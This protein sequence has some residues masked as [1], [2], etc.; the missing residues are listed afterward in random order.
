MVA[1]ITSPIDTLLQG[2]TRA[3]APGRTCTAVPTLPCK[4]NSRCDLRETKLAPDT[5]WG[6]RSRDPIGY[7]DG[8]CLYGQYIRMQHLDSM[9]LFCN[10]HC[11][12][13]F[14]PQ[15]VA[16]MPYRN[17][18][19]LPAA[20]GQV[21]LGVTRVNVED[22]ECTCKKD[23]GGWYVD[24]VELNVVA[25]IVIDVRLAKIFGPPWSLETVYGHEQRHVLNFKDYWENEGLRE[26]CDFYHA[27]NRPGCKYYDD[28]ITCLFQGCSGDLLNKIWDLKSEFIDREDHEPDN[29]S[30]PLPRTPYDPLPPGIG[31]QIK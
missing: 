19:P 14:M 24:S 29:D 15:Q 12:T 1:F 3:R 18:S 26:F 20:Q 4:P 11:S 27:Q 22:F 5:R 31:K 16:G 25:E 21:T 13:S 7:V 17:E 6:S 2:A 10:T 23:C 28:E 30:V 8:A 9:G